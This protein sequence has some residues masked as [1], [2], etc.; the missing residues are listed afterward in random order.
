MALRLIPAKTSIVAISAAMFGVFV[1]LLLGLPMLSAT[2][3]TSGVIA[4]L[5]AVAAVDYSR[6]RRAWKD[7]SPKLTRQLPAAL[8][9]GVTKPIQVFI[10]TAGT[11][12][13]KVRLY[14]HTDP[15]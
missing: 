9:L 7:A 3:L 12:S 4:G 13:F 8:A 11:E 6:S 2:I 15:T 1:A 5:A 14:D 10:D